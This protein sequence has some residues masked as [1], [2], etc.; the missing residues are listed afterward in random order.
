MLRQLLLVVFLT[1]SHANIIT[2]LSLKDNINEAEVHLG[3]KL[4]FDKNFSKDKTIS[5]AS[6]HS[7]FGSDKRRVSI[8]VKGQAGDIQS[9]SVFNAVNNYKQF[10]NGRANNLHE[11]VDFPIHNG[12]EMG[13]SQED[14]ENYLAINDEYKK[15]FLKVYKKDPS[16]ELFKSAL[17]SFE[18]TL[19]TLDSKFDQYLRNE[20]VLNQLE[21]QGFDLFKS[22]GC[23]SCHNGKN[24]GGNS[25]QLIGNV[26][27]YTY[28]EGQNDLYALTKKEVDKNVFR[29]PSLR[30]VT[31]TAPYFHDGSAQTLKEA[32]VTMAYHNLGLLLQNDEV[33]KIEAFLKTLEG[34]M[35]VTWN[36]NE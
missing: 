9:L 17:V 5:C 19:I 22:Y 7:D 21:E 18:Q 2:P 29:V 20:V 25:M 12:L 6:C 11:Q 33:E 35:P 28:Q 16:Y 23:A 27:P 1:Y 32:I 36:F 10:W 15:L 14:V 31:Q 34:K 26:I 8:G 13:I 4:F 3:K 30:N 24:V